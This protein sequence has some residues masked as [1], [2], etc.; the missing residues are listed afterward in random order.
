MSDSFLDKSVRQFLDELA[1]KAPVPGG[2]SVSA[3]T[4]SLAAGLV[5]MVC[6]LTLGKKAYAEVEQE[7]QEL[8]RQ[9]EAA[10]ARLQQLLDGDVAAYGELAAS[11]KLPRETEDEKAARDRAVQE[12][13]VLATRVPLEIAEASREAVELSGPAA[14]KGNKW[15]V[16]DAGIA[17]LLGEVA[18]H[19]ALMNVKIN[20]GTIEDEAFAA[21]V[22]ARM[23]KVLDGLA[24]RRA[25][26]IQ[27]VDERMGYSS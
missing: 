18:V 24:E 9:A 3:L 23:E 17:A 11:Y 25:E 2:G 22:R 19:S 7:M 27:I 5:T 21:E 13:T 20:L 8:R 12:A 16:S 4:G 1:S 6:D 10:R 15:A 26:I 14:V